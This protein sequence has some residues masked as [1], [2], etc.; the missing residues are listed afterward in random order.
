VRYSFVLCEKGSTMA[1]I[2]LIFDFGQCW[3]DDDDHPEGDKWDNKANC[4]LAS[5]GLACN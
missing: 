4:R 1:G 3:D 2:L 5:L